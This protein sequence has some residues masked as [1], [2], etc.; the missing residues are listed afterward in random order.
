M[1][2]QKVQFSEEA[3]KFYRAVPLE[4]VY[5]VLLAKPKKETDG[6]VRT[7]TK[8]TITHARKFGF[9]ASLT[10][11]IKILHS[12]TLEQWKLAQ[13]AKACAFNPCTKEELGNPD[14]LDAWI[15]RMT[16][17]SEE[18]KDQ[19]ANRGKQLHADHHNWIMSGR[20]QWPEDPV[21]RAICEATQR[22]L[23][24]WGAVEVK[25]EVSYG[26][27][28]LGYAFTPDYTVVCADGR[29][30]IPDLKT[31]KLQGFKD[32]YDSWKMQ[33][34]G[35]RLGFNKLGMHDNAQLIQQVSDQ[36]TGET[37]FVEQEDPEGWASAYEKLFG[38]WCQLNKYDPRKA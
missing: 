33:L 18:Y 2:P 14:L 30:V 3:C 38:V 17:K 9:L 31:T 36:E 21:S 25:S 20:T 35:E 26:S 37:V 6:T 28:E 8:A 10:Q 29:L 13:M 32:P 4:P 1:E 15:L 12:Y 22:M 7:T 11:T 16:A 19:R 23:D 5:E 24:S 27:R 34:G